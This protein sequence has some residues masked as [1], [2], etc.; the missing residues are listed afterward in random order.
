M[1]NSLILKAKDID[2][3]YQTVK[4]IRLE[5][6]KSVS[7]DIEENKISVIIGS[8]GAG[9]STLLHILGGLD[10]PDS[11]EVIFND[12]NIHHLSDDKLARFRNINIGFV[13]QFH[14][15]LPEFTALENIMIPLMINGISEKKSQERANELLIE[16][17]LSERAN[18]KPAELSGGEQQR[19]A[20]ARA[21]ANDP[22]LILADE[23]TGNLDSV[24]SVILQDLFKNLKNKLN[25]TFVIVTHN[26]ELISLADNLYEMKDGMIHKK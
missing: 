21:L 4:N 22:Q 14:H 6:L 20:V 15:L 18:H 23:P 13:F 9:K 10:K 1:S 8:S 24:N 5:I 3:A 17:G 2:K 7:I 12:T 25:K 26:Q 11:G 19:V 16:T